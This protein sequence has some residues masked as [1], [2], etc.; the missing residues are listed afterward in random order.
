MKCLHGGD[1][2][3]YEGMIDFSININP[4]GPDP[5]V[6]EAVK[7]AVE[8][9][10]VYPDS[11]CRKLKRSLGE[12][13]ELSEDMLVFGNGAADLIFSLAFAVK[14]KKALLCAPSF[15]EYERA[16]GAVDCEISWYDLKEENGFYLCPD[17]LDRLTEEVDIIFLCTPHNP[18]GNIIDPGLFQA[19]IEKCQKTGILAVVD[20]CFLDFLED[21]NYVHGASSVL[22][23]SHLF[24]LRAFTKIDS[25]PGLRLGYG[26]TA[27]QGLLQ[28]LEAV[29]QPWSVSILAQAAGLAA[30]Q[31]RAGI[32]KVRAFVKE[33]REGL[34]QEFD[35]LG[36]TYF[37]SRVNYIL[38]KSPYDLFT[39]LLKDGMLIR[40]CSNY[41]G[42][43]K[44]YYRVAVK[45]KEENQLLVKAL[46]RIYGNSDK[47]YEC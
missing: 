6:L 12:Q 13:L 37:P 11:Q 31:S 26:I 47:R 35:R 7:E 21:R 33:E 32:E 45:S 20:E 27:N 40:D 25:L 18:T 22:K 9:V 43:T 39:L 4:L 15:S 44:G 5:A 34:L 14:P 17:Y 29:R 1:I 46:E 36:I 3:T 30:L 19:I 42:L 8:Q 2:Y 41:R 23:C 28:K 16:L 38:L 10:G 24:L